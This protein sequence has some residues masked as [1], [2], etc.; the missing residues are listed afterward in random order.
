[1]K[2]KDVK[3]RFKKIKLIALDV[4]GVLTDGGIIIGSDGTEYKR[5][6]VKDGTGISL[7]R[8]GGL[9]FAVISGRHCETI[10]LRAKELKIGEVYQGCMEKKRAYEELKKKYGLKDSQVCFIGDEIIDLPVM[11]SCGL[12]AAPKDAA[13]EVKKAAHFISSAEGGK[14]CVREIIEKV[15]KSSGLWEKAVARYLGK[16]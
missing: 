4:D 14:G 11:L 6:D 2:K 1:M 9:K 16:K 3:E 10:G 7:G 12:A 13:A 8:H 15:L 5:F